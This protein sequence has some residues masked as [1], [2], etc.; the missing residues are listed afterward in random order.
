MLMDGKYFSNPIQENVILLLERLN[1]KD[2][3]LEMFP[4]HHKSSKRAC[5]R[6]H[7]R[8]VAPLAKT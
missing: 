5:Q 4:S 2:A 6:H 8:P 1:M 3:W 7:N